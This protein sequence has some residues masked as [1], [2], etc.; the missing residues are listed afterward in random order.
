MKTDHSDIQKSVENILFLLKEVCRKDLIDMIIGYSVFSVYLDTG[1][2]VI[3]D[4]L[5][6]YVSDTT[7]PEELLAALTIDGTEK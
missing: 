7:L 2:S 4:A 1:S 6:K 3:R 5:E